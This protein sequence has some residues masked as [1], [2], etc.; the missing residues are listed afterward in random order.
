MKKLTKKQRNQIYRAAL[1]EVKHFPDDPY[2]CPVLQDGLG[3]NEIEI[4]GMTI[5]SFELSKHFPEFYAF[6]KK[7]TH[8]K[9]CW[10]LPN[11]LGNLKRK[12]ALDKCI[13]LTK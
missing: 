8:A 6:K 1:H 3:N 7:G 2:V 13:E 10:W 5:N 12:E 11:R 4:E 9:V